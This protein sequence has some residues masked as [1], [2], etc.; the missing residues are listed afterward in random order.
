MIHFYHEISDRELYEICIS[1]LGGIEI[2]MD[3]LIEWIKA[4]PEMIDQNI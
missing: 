3:A 4:H 1:Q 2:L